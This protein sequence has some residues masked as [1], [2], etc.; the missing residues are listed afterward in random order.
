V[1]TA[2]TA[3]SDFLKT[4]QA[5]A[6]VKTKLLFTH[7]LILIM[8]QT[9]Q[10]AALSAVAAI[11]A[12]NSKE[13]HQGT[14]EIGAYNSMSGHGGHIGQPPG[15]H[16]GQTYG[17]SPLHGMLLG[18][19]YPSHGGRAGAHDGKKGSFFA[20]VHATEEVGWSSGR[21]HVLLWTI[22]DCFL[23]PRALC[24]CVTYLLARSRALSVA[25]ALSLSLSPLSLS[26]THSLSLV[27]SLNL[28]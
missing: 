27:R 5:L 24:V 15:I 8:S 25:L 1:R 2:E 10:R 6:C 9:K 14:H 20:G 26:R 23:A 11:T 17:T 7:I 19:G 3:Y 21:Q 18:S 28:I 16:G 12:R 22:S 13:H 4:Q